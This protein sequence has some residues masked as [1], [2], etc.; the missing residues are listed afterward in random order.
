MCLIPMSR[1]CRNSAPIFPVEMDFTSPN[2]VR[3]R[4]FSPRLSA[5]FISNG[6]LQILK[7]PGAN[8]TET[9]FA[10]AAYRQAIVTWQKACQMSILPL[11]RGLKWGLKGTTFATDFQ[12][13]FI[14]CWRHFAHIM[15][16]LSNVKAKVRIIHLLMMNVLT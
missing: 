1:T 11:F 16:V 3:G 12:S 14:L 5:Y 4:F 15:Y 7:V 2:K 8:K 6:Q 13:Q 9:L 10:D